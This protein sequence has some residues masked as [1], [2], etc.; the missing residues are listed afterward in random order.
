MFSGE[1]RMTLPE[2]LFYHA[3]EGGLLDANCAFDLA[4]DADFDTSGI[5]FEQWAETANGMA[6]AATLRGEILGARLFKTEDG[7]TFAEMACGTITDGDIEWSCE[8]AFAAS[9]SDHGIA[10]SVARVV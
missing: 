10:Y 6:I 2:F 1:S 8:A 3:S 4:R 7:Y 5:D 9:M